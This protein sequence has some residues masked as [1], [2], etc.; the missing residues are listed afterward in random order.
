MVSEAGSGEGGA[1]QGHWVIL[2]VG[3]GAQEE[4][5]CSGGLRKKGP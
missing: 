2:V 1:A 4:G 3:G 5:A